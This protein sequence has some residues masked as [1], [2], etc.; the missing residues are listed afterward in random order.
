M[1]GKYKIEPMAKV[2]MVP[3]SAAPKGSLSKTMIQEDFLEAGNV[4]IIST[5]LKAEKNAT[6]LIKQRLRL[7][8]CYPEHYLFVNDK[9]IKHSFTKRDYYLKDWTYE[10]CM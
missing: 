2:M 7:I 6:K 8:G 5:R 3:Y 4:Y 10:L 1:I 9:G